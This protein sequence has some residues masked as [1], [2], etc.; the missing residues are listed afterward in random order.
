MDRVKYVYM[1]C[2]LIVFKQA[3]LRFFGVGNYCLQLT[4]KK[5]NK[6]V[7][8][9]TLLLVKKTKGYCKTSRCPSNVTLVILKLSYHIKISNKA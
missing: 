5:H 6:K 1:F 3:F 4:A 2:F 9:A 8:P 7:A